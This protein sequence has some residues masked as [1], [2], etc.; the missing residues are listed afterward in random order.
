[1][2]DGVFYFDNGATSYP[3]PQVVIDEWVDYMTN[4]GA[5]PGRGNYGLSIEGGNRVLHTRELIAK[6]IGIRNPKRIVFSRNAT[7]SINTALFGLIQK[8]DHVI[9]TVTEHNAV[10]RPLNKIE[11]RGIAEVDW[12]TIDDDGILNV[13][14]ICSL[15]K[16]NTRFVVING[17]SNVTGVL[18]PVKEIGEFCIERGITYIIDAAQMLGSVPFDINEVGADIM[19]FTGH[20]NLLGP[21]GTGG[22]VFPIGLEPDPL[23][24]GGTGGASALECMPDEIPMK[25]EAGTSNAAGIS[26]LGKGVEFVIEKDPAK[27]MQHKIELA[28]Y[29]VEKTRKFDKLRL[30]GPQEKMGLRIGVVSFEPKHTTSKELAMQLWDFHKIAVRGGLHCAPMIH[31][32]LG[33]EKTGSIRFSFGVFNTIEQLDYAID[34]LDDVL[35]K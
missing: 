24:W 12:A 17:I 21:T 13:D 28:D 6:L 22:M 8:G 16:E 33:V 5:S 25:Y 23:V 31:D 11:K 34:A 14:T 3:K 7:E 29:F 15:K 27:I 26:A 19:C 18:A 10:R 20:K 32:A 30:L 35:K 2:R 4:V 1:M 9:S